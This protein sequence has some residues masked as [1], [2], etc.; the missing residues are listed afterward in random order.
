MK[1]WEDLAQHVVPSSHSTNVCVDS[2]QAGV[3]L[4]SVVV[5]GLSSAVSPVWI[6]ILH[7]CDP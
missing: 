1:C 6:Q 4:N 7:F 2:G 3:P 5:K